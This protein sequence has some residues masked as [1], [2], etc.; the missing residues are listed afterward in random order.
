[1]LNGLFVLGNLIQPLVYPVDIYEQITSKVNIVAPTQTRESLLEN[2]ELLNDVDVLFSGWGGPRLDEMFL[3]AAPNLKVIFYGAGSIRPLITPEFW[4][5][6]IQITNAVSANAVP[7]SLFT[8]SQILF[9][10]KGGWDYILQTERN[11]K[12]PGVN[13]NH[14]GLHKSTVGIISLGTIGLKVCELL[15]PT[16]L[17]ILAYDPFFD[18]SA[19]E[20][21]NITLSSLQNVF[22]Q[23]DV[24]S[25]HTPW[26]PET[27]GLITGELL[28][29]MKPYATFINTARGAVVNETEMIEVLRQRPDLTAVLD[30]TY[31]DPPAEDSPLYELPNVVM[32][33]HIAGAIT[34]NELRLLGETML[35]ELERYLNGEAL[36]HAVTRE[37]FS[38]MA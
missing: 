14:A 5:R 23:S 22:S 26:L 13:M 25:L 33:P 11:K 29:S 38:I 17:N 8:L 30:V 36:L 21:L 16:E 19:A 12:L 10:L 7:V 37:T 4:Q 24:V 15:K 27:V 32:T 1:M 31:P 2:P 35:H 9:S 34:R 3:K 20:N 28:A 6:D 18:V